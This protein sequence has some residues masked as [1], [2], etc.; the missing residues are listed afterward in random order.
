MP[1]TC[2][3]WL[4]LVKS[5]IYYAHQ[6][7]EIYQILPYSVDFKLPGSFEIHRVRQYLVNAVIFGIKDL[8]TSGM[9]IKLKSN[10]NIE[11]VN[12][13]PNFFTLLALR[14][15]YEILGK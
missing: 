15:F 10:L 11:P 3:N 13:F 6:T 4:G 1:M 14:D 5:C 12:I 9:T 2:E 7:C 8:Q